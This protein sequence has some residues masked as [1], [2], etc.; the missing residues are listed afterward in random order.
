[1]VQLPSGGPNCSDKNR[2]IDW[3]VEKGPKR[4]KKRTLISEKIIQ[5]KTNIVK[6]FVQ[7]MYW[8]PKNV[9][10]ITTISP[11]CDIIGEWEP[12][13]PYISVDPPSLIIMKV[14]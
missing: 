13:N 5:N 10:S 7:L 6:I 3:Q 4:K 8:Y 14:T 12:I 1:M 11:P 2:R 9:A